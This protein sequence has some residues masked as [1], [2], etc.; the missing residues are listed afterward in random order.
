MFPLLKLAKTAVQAMITVASS[1][2]GSKKTVKGNRNG[3]P[4]SSAN[5]AAMGVT[6]I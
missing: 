2:A 4:K 5:T 3:K 1:Q 6:R